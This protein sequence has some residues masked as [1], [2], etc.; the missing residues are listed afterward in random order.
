MPDL[1][2]GEEVFQYIVPK[3]QHELA[4]IDGGNRFKA[5]VGGPHSTARNGVDVRVNIQ[6]I[7]VA[8]DGNHDTGEGR[9]IAGNPLEHLPQGL[10]GGLAKD[11]EQAA[12]VFKDSAQKLG[13]GEDILGVADL[14]KDVSIEPLGKEQDTFLVACRTEAPAFTRVSENRLVVAA[15]ASKTGEA[16]MK[17]T[18]FKVFTQNL[19]DDPAPGAIL[20]LVALV[21]E[22]LEL[23]VIVLHQGIERTVAR[24]ARLVSGCRRDLHALHNSQV[25]R[26]SEKI[27]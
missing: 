12:V 9:R 2:A 20:L 25:W 13:D 18:A 11:A 14:L 19:A 27:A 26:L 23:L 22:A 21:V 5:A 10:P 15:A 4:G 17:V 3:Q 24:V 1:S 7:S 6:P 8:L 16:T